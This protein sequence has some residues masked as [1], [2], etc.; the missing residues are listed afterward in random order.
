MD[1]FLK[2]RHLVSWSDNCF[3]SG[4]DNQLFQMLPAGATTYTLAQYIDHALWLSGSSFT[5]GEMEEE[6]SATQPLPTQPI[7][8][9]QSLVILVPVTPPASEVLPGFP[10]SS[11]HPPRTQSQSP[12]Q[13]QRKSQPSLT[14]CVSRPQCL[15]R[16]SSLSKYLSLNLHSPY[17]WTKS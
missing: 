11:S 1:E 17:M 14:G 3:W 16:S 8:I 4:M 12:P 9:I 7:S 2:L 10:H 13:T 15:F 6:D 5:F